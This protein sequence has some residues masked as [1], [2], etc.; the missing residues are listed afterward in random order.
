MA[1]WLECPSGASYITQGWAPPLGQQDP[2]G[3][4]MRISNK[5]PW[6]ARTTLWEPRVY[7]MRCEQSLLSTIAAWV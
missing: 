3:P 2:V 7:R 5:F 4:R 1:L 6:E